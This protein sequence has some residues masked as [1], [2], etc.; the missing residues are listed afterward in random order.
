MRITFVL[1]GGGYSPVGGYKIVYEYA[2]RLTKCGH[3]VTVVHSAIVRMD[4]SPKEIARG[5][6]RFLYRKF[7]ADFKPAGWF[8]LDPNVRLL[9]VPSLS[10][11][12]IPDGDAVIATAWQT[13]E[14]IAQYPSKKGRKFYLIQGLE[15]WHGMEMRALATWKLPLRRFAISVHLMEVGHDLGV[16]VEYQPNGLDFQKFR[17]L[18]PPEKRDAAT[19]MMLYHNSELKGSADGLKAFSLV[20]EEVPKLRVTLFGTPARPVDLPSWIAYE[21]LPR[22]ERLCELYNRNAIFINP[23]LSE[24]WSLTPAE[25]MMCGAAVVATDIGGHRDYGIHEKTA[26]LCPVKDPVLLAKSILRLIHDDSLRNRIA[27]AGNQLI[28]QFTWEQSV[29]RLEA[30]LLE[31]Q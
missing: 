18:T 8:D 27:M 23:S 12:Y 11:Q 3:K 14:W 9:W 6:M 5:L 10:D 30:A 4:E 21:Q 2:N 28:Q 24:G 22:Q 31:E 26:L 7:V 20:R 1:P 13:S 25:A 15:T 17:L 16:K 19:V 29:S